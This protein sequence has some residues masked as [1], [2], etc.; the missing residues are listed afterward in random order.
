MERS[1][2]RVDCRCKV[3]SHHPSEFQ[4][5]LSWLWLQLSDIV[6]QAIVVPI[7]GFAHRLCAKAFGG[8]APAFKVLTYSSNRHIDEKK[9][10]DQRL[11]SPAG[12]KC[13]REFELIW[14]L[15]GYCF[16]QSLFLFGVQ[17]STTAFG[18]ASLF[19]FNRV[20]ATFFVSLVKRAGRR[21]MNPND[22][23]DLFVGFSRFAQP[24]YLVPKQLLCFSFK[25]ACV[26][27]FHACCIA[28]SIKNR[29]HYS[30]NLL[31]G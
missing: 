25:L 11:D 2:F 3:R 9:L 7:L 5:S 17:R 28:Y 23:A 16:F 21:R 26:Y 13:K 19:H 8:K 22:F 1:S 31:P 20:P 14:C 4:L 30:C 29:K 18:A 27:L 12:P 15:I 24:N 6:R 10:T